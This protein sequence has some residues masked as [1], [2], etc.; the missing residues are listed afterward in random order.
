MDLRT[1][2]YI[3][4]MELYIWLF[5]YCSWENNGRGKHSWTN[6]GVMDSCIDCGKEKGI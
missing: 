1:R 5:G 4:Y 2:L 6:Y 3:W